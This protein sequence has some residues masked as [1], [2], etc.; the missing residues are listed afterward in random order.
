MREHPL[1]KH[2]EQVGGDEA[3]KHGLLHLKFTSPGRASVP[4]RLILAPIP[5]FLRDVI[6]K[7]VRFVEYKAHGKKA[8]AQQRREHDRLRKMGFRVDVIDDRDAAR[9]NI[10]EMIG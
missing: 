5:E 8:T 4:D 1:E 6:A 9:A 2:V 3:R 10:R 7:H